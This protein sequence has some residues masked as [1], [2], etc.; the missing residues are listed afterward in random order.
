MVPYR[1]DII[2]PVSSTLPLPTNPCVICCAFSLA[3]RD[4]AVDEMKSQMKDA[5]DDWH[6]GHNFVPEVSWR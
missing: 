3:R 5:D 6:T 1:N 4:I 2:L